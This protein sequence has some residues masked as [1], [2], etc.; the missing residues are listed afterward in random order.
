[1]ID[2]GERVNIT[3][4]FKNRLQELKIK[5]DITITLFK[6]SSYKI[7][8][9]MAKLLRNVSGS[10]AGGCVTI[11]QV[12]RPL[13]HEPAGGQSKFTA[14]H[15]VHR[16]YVHARQEEGHLKVRVQ[17]AHLIDGTV[18]LETV[19]PVERYHVQSCRYGLQPKW[20]DVERHD[21][22]C[23]EIELIVSR[24]LIRVP[25]SPS[26]ASLE[27]ALVTLPP[28]GV[29]QQRKVLTF[30]T[31]A[32]KRITDPRVSNQRSKLTIELSSVQS[33]L[34]VAGRTLRSLVSLDATR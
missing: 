23:P 2:P 33:E 27:A 16:R 22:R 29:Y 15:H 13:E 34:I 18:K 31:A 9:Q 4:Q 30:T 24:K 21:Q 5:Q 12:A 10:R 32:F 25:Q 6:T 11:F 19:A 20:Q 8:V 28:P 7:S 26:I 3:E 1:M 14:A 17:A